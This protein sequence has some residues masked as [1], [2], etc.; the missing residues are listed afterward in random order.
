MGEST[1]SGNDAGSDVPDRSNPNEMAARERAAARAGTVTDGSG[2]PV[3]STNADGTK[4]VVTS[5]NATDFE[6]SMAQQQFAAQTGNPLSNQAQQ[7]A[8]SVAER[9]TAA[10]NRAAEAGRLA[11]AP[12]ASSLANVGDIT[13]PAAAL[14][15][16][17][18]LAFTQGMSGGAPRIGDITQPAGTGFADA[19]TARIANLTPDQAAAENITVSRQ[20]AA[21]AAMQGRTVNPVTGALQGPDLINIF[22]ETDLDPAAG[23]EA[24][25]ARAQQEMDLRAQALSAI[26]NNLG[27]ASASQATAANVLGTSPSVFDASPNAMDAGDMMLNPGLATGIG[28]LPTPGGTVRDLQ[29]QRQ[30]QAAAQN[31]MTTGQAGAAGPPQLVDRS[32]NPENIDFTLNFPGQ[33]LDR[34]VTGGVTGTDVTTADAMDSALAFGFDGVNQTRVPVTTAPVSSVFEG[35]GS[36]LGLGQREL[37]PLEQSIQAAAAAS[38]RTPT[39]QAGVTPTGPMGAQA[40]AGTPAQDFYADVYRDFRGT[41]DQ[42][43]EGNIPGQ[44]LAGISGGVTNLFGGDAPSAQ[45]TAAFQSGQL[46]SL[47]GTMDPETGAIS[48]AQAGR[49]TLNMNRF[50]M[51]TYSGMPDPNYDGPFAN[52]VN[53]PADTGGDGGQQMQ[54]ATADPCPEGYQMRDGVCQPVDDLIQQPDP[55]GSD[56]V[57]NPTTGLPTLFTPATQAT[58]VG[59]INP[60]VLQPY[61]SPPVGI[62]PPQPTQ[63]IQG[64][65]PTGAA[66]GRQV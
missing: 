27:I 12:A 23:Q 62:N 49:G 47:G 60:F 4:S 7:L 29:A 57:I 50:G 42:P 13:Q 51:V 6:R 56:F 20:R 32:T 22:S 3:T 43:F 17:D 40:A 1:D 52:L 44:T 63:G 11:S 21:Q 36:N 9:E 46:L 54:Q 30:Q 31:F 41:P 53:P 14:G 2:N 10:L 34:T 61:A 16:D 26:Q 65:S 25:R 59:Q 24:Q 38:S 48:G 8:E 45:D 66:L 35:L 5:G 64:L 28:S 55:P 18:E 58:Q 37:S 19:E 39:Q 33:E 15:L